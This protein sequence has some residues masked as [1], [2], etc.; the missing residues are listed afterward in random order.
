[1]RKANCFFFFG[2]ALLLLLLLLL[3]EEAEEAEDSLEVAVMQ[4]GDEI[5]RTLP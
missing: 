5:E 4:R 1:M 3:E 2:V